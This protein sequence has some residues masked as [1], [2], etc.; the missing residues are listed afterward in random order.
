MHT[1][2]GNPILSDITVPRKKRRVFLWFFLAVQVLFVIWIIAGS[3]SHVDTSNCGS[4]AVQTCKDAQN[5]GKGIGAVLVVVLWVIVDFL[6]GMT[7]IVYKL[8]KR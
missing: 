4:L 1:L 2:E 8:A 5:V 3:S 7:Y 6:L